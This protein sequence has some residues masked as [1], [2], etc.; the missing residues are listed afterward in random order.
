MDSNVNLDVETCIKFLKEHGY[1]VS[2]KEKPVHI[3][4]CACGYKGTEVWYGAN[5]VRRVC[6]HCGLS[7]EPAKTDKQAKINYNKAVKAKLDELHG[8]K[9]FA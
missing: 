6:K 7:G 1:R 8:S 3:S 4:T 9:L 2:K 5:T